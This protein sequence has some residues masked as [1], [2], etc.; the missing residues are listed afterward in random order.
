MAR[1]T[2]LYCT[3]TS[4]EQR[5]R[6]SLV[7]ASLV[8]QVTTVTSL[9]DGLRF[10][11]RSS[12]ELRDLVEEFVALEQDCCSFLTFTLSQ[13][14]EKLSLLISGPPEAAHVIEMFRHAVQEG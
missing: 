6:R 10:E 4:E 14:S 3:L 13:S 11:F 2:A 9:L 8:P 1:E 12:R 7:R 5:I